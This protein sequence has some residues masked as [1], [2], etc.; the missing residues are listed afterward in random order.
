MS[1]LHLGKGTKEEAL[2]SRCCRFSNF[3]NEH[4][5]K[6]LLFVICCHNHKCRVV[7]IRHSLSSLTNQVT[8][9]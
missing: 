3:L 5:F 1:Y 9:C 7:V 2:I 8:L 6:V 4:F